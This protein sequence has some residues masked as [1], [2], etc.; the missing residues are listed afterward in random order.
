MLPFLLGVVAIVLIAISATLGQ[1]SLIIGGVA[2]AL[3]LIV[4]GYVYLSSDR[5]HRGGA[6]TG[7]QALINNVSKAEIEESEADQKLRQ[8]AEVLDLDFPDAVALDNVESVLSAS[9]TVNRAWVVIQ[10][11]LLDAIEAHDQQKRRVENASGA[12]TAAQEELDAAQVD[13][14]TWLTDRGLA[15]TLT[16]ETM[17]EFRGSVDTARVAQGEVRNMRLRVNA[18]ENDIDEYHELVAPLAEIFGNTIGSEEP[19]ESSASKSAKMTWL[20]F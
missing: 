2:G 4:A 6:P 10:Q 20:N 18:I 12:R 19:R 8:A 3:V 7:N 1:P 9:D 14:Q 5:N 17:V 11:R 13:W 15:K 16:P